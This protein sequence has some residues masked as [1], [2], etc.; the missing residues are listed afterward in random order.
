MHFI[1]EMATL[2]M[3]PGQ[4]YKW[5]YWFQIF[6]WDLGLEWS[7]QNRYAQQTVFK[8]KMSLPP[9]CLVQIN[10][11]NQAWITIR[12]RINIYLKRF[13]YNDNFYFCFVLNTAESVWIYCFNSLLSSYWCK[14]QPSSASIIFI[15]VCVISVSLAVTYYQVCC[16][17]LP[18][19]L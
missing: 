11:S 6:C 1:S 3:H 15:N 10:C 14:R 17:I 12:V 7:Q 16:N 4:F 19:M 13:T 18:C 5:L 8:L 2:L 9:K